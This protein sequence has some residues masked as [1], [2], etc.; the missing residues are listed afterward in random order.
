ME[1]F[2]KVPAEAIKSKGHGI[3]TDRLH[4]IE[5]IEITHRLDISLRLIFRLCIGPTRDDK[6]SKELPA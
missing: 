5:R 3:K 4:E 6:T 1:D 2:E